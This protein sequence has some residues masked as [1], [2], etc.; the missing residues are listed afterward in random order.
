M[1][2]WLKDLA[3]GIRTRTTT[4]RAGTDITGS[5]LFETEAEA[6]RRERRTPGYTLSYR[7]PAGASREE[8]AAGLITAMK[9]FSRGK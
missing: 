2:D 5:A 7:S 3:A 8:R 6:K 9:H 1:W 4:E